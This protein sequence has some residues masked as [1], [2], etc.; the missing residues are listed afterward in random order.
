[1]SIAQS[2]HRLV[3]E[4]ATRHGVGRVAAVNL[5]IGEVSGVVP[6][7][8]RLCWQMLTEGGPAQGSVLNIE[9]LP[10]MAVCNACGAEFRIEAPSFTCPECGGDEITVTQ[11]REMTIQSIS[12]D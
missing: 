7:S 10:L 12:G 3:L 2:I 11:G 1:M 4:E 8:L 6:E 5:K 9:T